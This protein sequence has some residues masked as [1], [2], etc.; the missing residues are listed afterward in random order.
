MARML[1][2]SLLIIGFILGLTLGTVG[3]C[4]P[5]LF[6]NIFTFDAMVI[7]EMHK[8][9]IPFFLALAVTPCTHSLEGTLLC[10]SRA[11]RNENPELLMLASALALH[12]QPLMVTA[13]HTGMMEHCI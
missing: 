11:L 12:V 7:Q 2:K 13:V 4:V 1:L 5:W 8:V 3:T 9:L 6:P 10:L